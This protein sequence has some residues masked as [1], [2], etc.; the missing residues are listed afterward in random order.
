[1]LN[2]PDVQAVSFVG[3]TPIA[4]YIYETATAN[5]KRVQALGGA[6]NHSLVLPDADLNMAADAIVGAAYGSA[7]ERC[8]AL[9]VVLA[10]DTIADALIDK[11]KERMPAIQVGPATEEGNEMGPLITG[12]HRDKVAGYVGGAEAEGATLVVD[13]RDGAPT[14]GFFLRPSL[15]D[16]VAPGM[17]VYDEEIF[18]PVLSITRVKSYDEGLKLINDNPYGNGT[19]IFTRDGG[20][21]RQFQFDVQVGMV[22]INV[23]V[24]VPVS[25]YSFGG[26]KAS[27]F[28]DTNM[29]GPEGI[30]FFTR[31]K[32]VTS[33]WPDPHTSSV[34][35]GFPQNR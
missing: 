9:S 8:M 33:R 12:E 4:K 6:K 17:K 34:D 19:A 27:L 15:I 31:S 30:N 10:V 35:L 28:G 16:N 11:I 14:N 29:Y 23:P 24:P 7:G 2:H 1:L 20:A 21:A 5:G 3:S 32:V 25:Y 26:W 18:G 22:G 13:G